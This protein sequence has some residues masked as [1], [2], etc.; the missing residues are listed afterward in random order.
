MEFKKILEKLK[1]IQETDD[2]NYQ[3]WLDG[4]SEKTAA[5]EVDDTTPAERSQIRK[6]MS[7]NMAKDSSDF[8]AGTGRFADINRN[9]QKM[10]GHAQNM[11]RGQLAAMANRK[12]RQQY[13]VQM[14]D[15]MLGVPKGYFK[16]QAYSGGPSEMQLKQQY[17]NQLNGQAESINNKNRSLKESIDPQDLHELVSKYENGELNYK[18]LKQ[19]IDGLESDDYDFDSFDSEDSD[20]IDQNSQD[21]GE[22]AYSYGEEDDFYSPNEYRES[23]S[24]KCG[25]CKSLSEECDMTECGGDS[26]SVSMPASVSKQDDSVSMTVN[27]SGSGSGGIKDILDIL[28]NI[29]SGS[30]SSGSSNDRARDTDVGMIVATQSEPEFEKLQNAPNER[31]SALKD[32]IKSGNDLHRSKDSYSDMPYRGD[33]PMAIKA[34]LESLYNF[35]KSK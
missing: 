27:M 2:E 16:G 5:P 4:D 35:V 24:T 18:E 19:A 6:R 29:E 1:A 14:P 17:V 26:A 34:K 8:W 13:S 31:Y 3:S 12:S 10:K 9:T 11:V 28:R 15:E 23:V 25:S 32:I 7:T 21:D 22:D 20:Y 33:N 30:S